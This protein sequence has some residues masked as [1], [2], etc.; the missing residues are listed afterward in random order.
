MTS[1][2]GSPRS[3]RCS[4]SRD[5]SITSL[6]ARAKEYSSVFLP[7]LAL[8]LLVRTYLVA[9][10]YIPSMSMYPTLVVNDQVAVETFSRFLS[11]PARGG[12]RD[13]EALPTSKVIELTRQHF[14]KTIDELKRKLESRRE[15][16]AT[17]T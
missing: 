5:P 1:T 6:L 7:A 2:L 12:L 17:G 11:S 13:A 4:R 10:Y 3:R 14:I 15:L 8:F 16:Q 9:P